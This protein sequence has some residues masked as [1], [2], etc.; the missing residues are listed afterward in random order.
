[1]P[2]ESFLGDYQCPAKVLRCDQIK[3]L[4]PPRIEITEVLE[5]D[6]VIFEHVLSAQYLM[7]IHPDRGLC[8]YTR[9]NVSKPISAELLVQLIQ[10][11]ECVNDKGR[12]T[13]I[14]YRDARELAVLILERA[15]ESDF[16]DGKVCWAYFG[17]GRTGTE[18]DYPNKETRLL[19]E[20]AGIHVHDGYM[21]VEEWQ[22]REAAGLTD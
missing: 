21:Y 5:N 15:R 2:D 7:S 16:F 12:N 8:Y 10:W 4:E 18:C 11:I 3:Q 1:M 6:V 19:C 17:S 13:T 9:A 20:L 22:R 14:C